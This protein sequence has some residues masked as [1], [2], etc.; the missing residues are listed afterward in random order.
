MQST[1][2]RV[3]SGTARRDEARRGGRSSTSRRAL[4][5]QVAA[6]RR[7]HGAAEDGG[8]GERDGLV[9]GKLAKQR[10]ERHQ[11]RAAA[12]ARRG[13]EDGRKED[14]NGAVR[15]RLGRRPGELGVV[16]GL[17]AVALSTN[18]RGRWKQVYPAGDFGVDR[19]SSTAV[20]RRG[21]VA[22]GGGDGGG[23]GP[24]EREGGGTELRRREDR[25]GNSE[26]GSGLVSSRT[27]RTA[28]C[29]RTGTM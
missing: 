17:A 20:W 1:A 2:R 29:R 28:A 26:S 9:L 23:D 4:G 16:G 13:R 12:D 3:Q 10:E 25:R 6:N 24:S 5:V 15:V 18:D 14:S 7:E 11:H 21:G 8:D 27:S 19:L 22:S